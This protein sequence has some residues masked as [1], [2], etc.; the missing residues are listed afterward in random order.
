[1]CWGVSILQECPV[2]GKRISKSALLILFFFL[3]FIFLTYYFCVSG[4]PMEAVCTEPCYQL[5]WVLTSK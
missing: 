4:N 2:S 5:Q 3:L 1:M